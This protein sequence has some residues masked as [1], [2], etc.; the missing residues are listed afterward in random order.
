MPLHPLTRVITAANSKHRDECFKV[1]DIR[2]SQTSTISAEFVAKHPCD[3][4]AA[5]YFSPFEIVA[6]IGRVAYK[7]AL[8]VDSKI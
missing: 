8:P 6:Q 2:F 3:K 5:R 1:A 4:L 7:L